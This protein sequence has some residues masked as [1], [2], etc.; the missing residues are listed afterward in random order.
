ML[1]HINQR[2]YSSYH[3]GTIKLDHQPIIIKSPTSTIPLFHHFHHTHC[4]LPLWCDNRRALCDYGLEVLLYC[5]RLAIDRTLRSSAGERIFQRTAWLSIPDRCCFTIRAT[6][7]SHRK[8][9]IYTARSVH[10]A[11]TCPSE[12]I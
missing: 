1:L 7:R 5:P 10:H 9:I 4:S 8:P 2:P 12:A 3:F 6:H 11:Q